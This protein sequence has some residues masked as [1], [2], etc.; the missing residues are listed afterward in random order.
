MKV[1]AHQ[2]RGSNPRGG[3]GEIGPVVPPR[4]LKACRLARSQHGRS[5]ATDEPDPGADVESEEAI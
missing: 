4:S 3:T 2:W 5:E 1:E